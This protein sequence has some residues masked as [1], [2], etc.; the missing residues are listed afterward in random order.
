MTIGEREPLL[1]LSVAGRLFAFR[2]GVIREVVFLPATASLP[3]QPS[4]LH[5]FLNLRGE[6]IAV[7]SLRALFQQPVVEPWLY[8]PVIVLR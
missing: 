2:T 1:T 8:A 7:V 6:L 4:I 5:G 3:A